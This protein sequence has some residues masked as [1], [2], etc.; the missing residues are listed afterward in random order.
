MHHNLIPL[1]VIILLINTSSA[2]SIL[3]IIEMNK[4]FRKIP[5]SKLGVSEPNPSWFGNPGNEKNNSNW[6]NPNWLKSRF[7]FS[8]AEYS[9]PHNMGFGILRVMN[10]DLVQ[11]NRGFGTHP[12]R[13]MEICTYIVEGKLTHKDSMGSQ[14]SLGRGGVQFMVNNH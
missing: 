13:D 2:F 5:N 11:P 12:H 8:F 14:E 9:N 10:D 3:V 1:L 7:H 6:T 4:Y